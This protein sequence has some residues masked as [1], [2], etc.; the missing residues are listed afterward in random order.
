MCESWCGGVEERVECGVGEA[1][2]RVWVGFEFEFD[3]G[4]DGEYGREWVEYVEV[5]NDEGECVKYDG[6][7]VGWGNYLDAR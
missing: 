4:R 2:I 6:G 5:W 7:D 3:V 1:R